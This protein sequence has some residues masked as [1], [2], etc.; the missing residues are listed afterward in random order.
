[1]DIRLAEPGYRRWII[2]PHPGDLQWA[3]GQAATPYGPILVKWGQD[4]NGFTIQLDAPPGT[5]GT[6]AIPV[7]DGNSKLLVNGQIAWESG[8]VVDKSLG[9]QTDSQFI[10]L[11]NLPGSHFYIVS[12]ED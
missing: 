8:H 1:L 4:E 6:V 2:Q 9:I 7:T 5:V 11:N 12:E 10:Y 3:E